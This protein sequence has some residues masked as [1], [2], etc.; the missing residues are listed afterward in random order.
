MLDGLTASLVG[1]GDG[2]DWLGLWVSRDFV[3]VHVPVD[4]GRVVPRNN[5]RGVD[6][7]DIEGGH[8]RDIAGGGVL[9]EGGEGGGGEEGEREEGEESGDG[10]HRVVSVGLVSGIWKVV[11]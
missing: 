3:P 2:S 7:G 4:F 9:V 8:G 10:R 5:C 11:C 1:P 6:G